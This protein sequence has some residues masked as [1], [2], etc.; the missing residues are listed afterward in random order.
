MTSILALSPWIALHAFTV[1][2]IG[3]VT[4]GMMSRVALGHT[5]RNVFDPPSVLSKV[6]GLLVLGAIL[7]VLFPIVLPELHVWWIGLSQLCWIIGF[8]WFGFI[9]APMLVKARIDN[10]FG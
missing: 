7:R 1:G 5:G 9:Y 2:G 8:G 6:F 3:I 10:K 4:A